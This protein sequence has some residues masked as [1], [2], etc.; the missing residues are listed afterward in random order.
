MCLADGQE[1]LPIIAQRLE[2]ILEDEIHTLRCQRF[3]VL[4]HGK[5]EG[6]TS[7]TGFE[8]LSGTNKGIFDGASD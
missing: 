4:L 7:P 5:V 3:I 8:F 1:L 6:E 2:N